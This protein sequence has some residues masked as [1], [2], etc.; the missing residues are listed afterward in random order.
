MP[1]NNLLPHSIFPMKYIIFLLIVLS[2][3]FVSASFFESEIIGNE[4][5]QSRIDQVRI[6]DF[7]F[8]NMAT[9]AKHAQT[10]FFIS[11]TKSEILSRYADGRVNEYEFADI[12]NNLEYVAHS[13]NTYF[14]NM[15]AFERS[16]NR[17]YR[18]LALQNLRDSKGAY[19]RL[20][21]DTQKSIHQP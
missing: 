7:T 6:I 18:T 17:V 10:K 14:T 4:M 13:M 5:V 1:R 21:A 9:S 2:P 8:K 11:K 19:E 20:R 12:T 3:T 16:N 15:K